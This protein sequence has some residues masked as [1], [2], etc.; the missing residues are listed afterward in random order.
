ME[1]T[2]REKHLI[3]VKN[4]QQK[5]KEILKEKK[6]IYKQKNEDRLKRYSKYYYNN[7][8]YYKNEDNILRCVK[9]LFQ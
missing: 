9:K 8:F 1:L 7:Q 5:N 3:S 2:K 6:K 4:Y